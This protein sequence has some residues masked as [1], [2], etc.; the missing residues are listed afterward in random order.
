MANASR[1]AAE[2][3]ARAPDNLPIGVRAP[4][5]MT[6]PGM[7]QVYG[8]G[9]PGLEKPSSTTEPGSADVPS[10]RSAHS[11]AMP[12]SV[13]RRYPGVMGSD[14]LTEVDHVA[15]AVRD[16]DAAV[17]WYADA[18]D[19][20]VAHREVVERDGVEE[21]LLAVADSYVQLL[22]PTVTTLLSP[23]ISRPGARDSTTSATG[24]PIAARRCGRRWP[25]GPAPSTQSL[26]PGSRGTTVAFLHPKTAL[27]HPDR[28]GPGMRDRG[29]SPASAGL[30]SNDPCWCGSGR[31]YKRCHRATE[32]RVLPG[33]VSAMRDVPD[34]IVP[35]DYYRSG[36][37]VRRDEPM[38]K[39]PDV[40]ARMRVAGQV[41][42]EVLAVTGRGGRPG[43]D[44]RGAR[45]HRPPGLHRPG[46]LS[47]DA[48]LPRLPEVDLHLGQRGDLPRDPGRPAPRGG[49]HRQHRRHGLPRRRPRRL[50][51]HLLRRRGGCRPPSS[52]WR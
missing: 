19:A 28:A 29:L 26:G 21:A 5:T 51:R 20:S 47:L 31:K 39:S 36:I 33:H 15:I 13:T 38:V 24:W 7:R 16:L 27:R 37:P 40:I 1:S 34:H 2:N 4:A 35:T 43:R 10:R 46:R 22:T 48:Q 42:A 18:F 52:S 11:V 9:W 6:E 32:G 12:S 14:I 50:Q 25:P 17:A 49:R 41:A 8:A 30:K 44:H 23:S 45:P 3:G